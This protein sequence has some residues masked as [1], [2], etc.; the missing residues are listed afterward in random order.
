MKQNKGFT[1]MEIL[2]VLLVIAVIASFAVPLI[3]SVRREMQ[4][5]KAKAAGVQLAE[6]VRSFYADSKGCFVFHDAESDQSVFYGADAAGGSCPNNNPV[7]TGVPNYCPE[8]A[9]GGPQAVFACGYLSPKIFVD[10]PYN[11]KVLDPRNNYEDD[12][13]AEGS[14]VKGMENMDGGRWFVVN[15]DMTITED[16]D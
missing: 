12:G 11:F 4:Y 15:R 1:L 16:D 6:A 9:A 2:A 13:F 3:K 5:Q 10:L 14:F 8:G 7:K